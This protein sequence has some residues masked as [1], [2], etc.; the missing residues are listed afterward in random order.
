MDNT[1]DKFAGIKTW[2]A[3]FALV[4]MILGI[5]AF[6]YFVVGDNGQPTWE[7]RPVKDVPGESPYAVYEPLPYKQHVRGERGE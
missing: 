5:G 7:Y 4:A 6:T 1:T 3:I 2:A